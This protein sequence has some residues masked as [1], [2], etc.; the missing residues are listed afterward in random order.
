M[1]CLT[2]RPGGSSFDWTAILG[3]V[4]DCGA[5]VCVRV[6]RELD[7]RRFWMHTVKV[8]GRLHANQRSDA[9][10]VPERVCTLTCLHILDAASD[11]ACE[12]H[13][14]SLPRLSD[15]IIHHCLTLS[16]NPLHICVD[17]PMYKSTCLFLLQQRSKRFE[18]LL[19]GDRLPHSIGEALMKGEPYSSFLVLWLFRLLPNLPC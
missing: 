2:V 14:I 1:I 18:E 15:K 7:A 17:F 11:A 13:R 9:V 16:P 12:E 4:I 19:Q 3:V 5:L 8:F 6:E 10:T